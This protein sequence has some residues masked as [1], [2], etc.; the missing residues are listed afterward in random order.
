MT[1]PAA[2]TPGVEPPDPCPAPPGVVLDTN[3]CLDLLLFGDPR[4]AALQAALRAGRVR[5]L[6]DADCRA[7]WHRVLAYPQWRLDAA[8]QA[9]QQARLDGLVRMQADACAHDS[10]YPR[11]PRCRDGDDQKF[12]ELAA[13]AGARWL[14]TRDDEL[15]R[16][17]RRARQ[18]CGFDILT[19]EA[20]A[21]AQATLREDPHDG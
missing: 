8:A 13:R 14:L 4:T 12:L 9:E 5:A 18:A 19:P 17:S 16:L 15:L 11:P 21:L 1:P 6:C 2:T 20:W 3:V 7:E 10:P